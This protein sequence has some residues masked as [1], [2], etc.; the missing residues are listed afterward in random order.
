[1]GMTTLDDI[2]LGIE[3]LIA[4]QPPTSDGKSFEDGDIG[5]EVSADSRIF[6]VRVLADTWESGA[7][8]S[9][10]RQATIDI[11]IQYRK[12]KIGRALMLDDNAAF[13]ELVRGLA[14]T[15]PVWSPSLIPDGSVKNPVF[16]TPGVAFDHS[17]FPGT[18]ALSMIAI[19]LSYHTTVEV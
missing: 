16:L 15:L 9:C 11:G 8:A 4:A 18:K 2:I 14:T 19:A 7:L 5:D 10:W 1:M 12:N 6:T 17:T 3:A 13:E